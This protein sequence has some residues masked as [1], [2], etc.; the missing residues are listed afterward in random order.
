M[1]RWFFLS[2]ILLAGIIYAKKDS[3]GDR[4]VEY[5]TN[6]KHFTIVVIKDD[7]SDERAKKYALKRA[8]EIT[9]QKGYR[10]FIIKAEEN[11]FFMRGKKDWPNAYDFPQDLYQEEIIE[12]GFN[13]ER[14]IEKD[15]T[16]SSPKPALRLK[17][18]CTET[19]TESSFDACKYT[20][21][22]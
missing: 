9:V 15:E 16:D 22:K 1:L 18:E 13:R 6:N 5:N 3:M 4:I 7:L 11:V 12:K 17:I 8:A 21:C 19:K 2:F 10:Y 20:E 14:F